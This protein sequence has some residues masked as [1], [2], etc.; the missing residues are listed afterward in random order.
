MVLELAFQNTSLIKECIVFHSSST[1]K[2]ILILKS[3]NFT[4]N[5]ELLLQDSL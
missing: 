1:K 5:N 4:P 2:D 3:A